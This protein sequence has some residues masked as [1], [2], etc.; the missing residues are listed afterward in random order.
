MRLKVSE[1]NVNSGW[2]SA[3]KAGTYENI[4][5]GFVYKLSDEEE[6]PMRVLSG[7]AGRKIFVADPGKEKDKALLVDCDDLAMEKICFQPEGARPPN[8]SLVIWKNVIG[9]IVK[10]D[11]AAA[12]KEKNLVESQQREIR[13]AREARGE[14]FVPQYFKYSEEI[15]CWLPLKNALENVNVK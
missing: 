6:T 15:E 10:D 14:E 1:V 13:R 3:V 7:H 5:E 12:D 11:V 8:S 9:H 2:F 4:V